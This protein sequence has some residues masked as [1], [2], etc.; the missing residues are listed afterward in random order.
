[1]QPQD[2]ST[3]RKIRA[4]PWFYT[5]EAANSVFCIL[6]WFGPVLPLF[7][8]A[9]GLTKTRIGLILAIPFLC[10]PFS[11]L[12]S[13]WVLRWGVKKTFLWGFAVRAFVTAGLC[14]TPLML[15]GFEGLTAFGWVMAITVV[16]SLCRAI[17]ET[18]FFPWY[19]EF[20]PIHLRGKTVAT[21]V[22]IA[23]LASLLIS[24]LAAA[25]L[26]HITGLGGYS[27]L[28]L[29]SLPFGI[30]SVFFYG[31]I[32]GGQP[33]QAAAEPQRLL[34]DYFQVLKDRN[35]VTYECGQCLL[36]LAMAMLAF[37]P[38]FLEGP[39]NLGADKIFILSACSLV[40]LLASAFLWGWSADR[41]GGK[42]VLLTS[43]LLMIFLP[44][45]FFALPRGS[46]WTMSAAI[47][48]YL[49]LGVASNGL[50]VGGNRYFYAGVIPVNER[51][52]AYYSVHYTWLGLAA[53]LGP[54]LAGAVLDWSQGL[55][56]VARW[57]H[58]D[59]FAPLFAL[60]LVMLLAAFPVL[61]RVRKDGAVRLGEYMSMFIHGNPLLAFN[62]M[63]RYRFATDEDERLATTRRLGD[64]QN[65][66]SVAELLEAVS[67]PSFNVRYEAIVA[68]ARMP[69]HPELTKALIAVL[70]SKE[71]DL[72][73]TAGWALGRIG[74]KQAIP[75]LRRALISE[76]ALLRSR[77]ARSLAILSDAEAVPILFDLFNSEKQDSIRVAYASA[78]GVL[79]AA[80]ALDDLLALLCRLTNA[81]LRGEVALAIARIIGAEHHFVRLWRATRSDFG[82]GVATAIALQRKRVGADRSAPSGVAAALAALEQMMAAQD[83]NGGA[84]ALSRLIQQLPLERLEGMLRK[85]LEECARRL[86]APEDAQRHDY[87]ILALSGLA[88]ALRRTGAAVTVNL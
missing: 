71:P 51:S 34:P 41:F 24:L 63:I 49:F 20:L 31:L 66:L 73:V 67:D 85:V 11:L 9:L 48:T 57:P 32:P 60:S 4:F 8:N 59:Q 69:P 21:C 30:A 17:G 3:A 50:T 80:R 53:G 70:D 88:L 13:R 25:V 18:G 79:H 44:L 54:P 58:V 77:S 78:L 47:M 65:L 22:S 29:L 68:M 82:T 6:S 16:F 52:Q 81:N 55:E 12:V 86:T 74:D 26:K 5:G 46:A 27:L 87:V 7:L 62:S 39:V 76:Y 83:I 84:A 72:S 40:G 35:F 45:M 15:Q 28:V 23:G 75:A 42:P 61:S 37:L 10:M 33:V 14:A 1:M 56:R 2:I 19:R 36:T 43:L 38:L 64:A